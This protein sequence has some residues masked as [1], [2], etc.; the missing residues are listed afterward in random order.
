MQ[1]KL[2]KI[3]Y[4]FENALACSSGACWVRI[5]KKKLVILQGFL[6]NC[7]WT[8]NST[9]SS[10]LVISRKKDKRANQQ[11]KHNLPFLQPTEAWLYNIIYIVLE[12]EHNLQKKPSGL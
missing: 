12:C 6:Q 2:D 7:Y 4:K 11:G 5:M 10:N 9:S 3:E 8:Q 1:K